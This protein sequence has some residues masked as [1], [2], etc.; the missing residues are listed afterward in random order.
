MKWSEVAERIAD[1]IDDDGYFSAEGREKYRKSKLINKILAEGTSESLRARLTEASKIPVWKGGFDQNAKEIYGLGDRKFGNGYSVKYTKDG[2]EAEYRN[3]ENPSADLTAKCSWYEA[4]NRLLRLIGQGVWTANTT[5]QSSEN[6]LS[7]VKDR[8]QVIDEEEILENTDLTDVLDQSELGGAKTRFKGNVEAI[9]LVNRLYAENRNSTPEEKKIL[10][11][12]VGWGGLSQAFDATN[13]EW[14]KEYEE[15][16]KVLSPE[17]YD[18]A[19]GS[20]LNAHYTS[21]EVIEGIYKALMRFGVRGNNRILEPAMGT[22]NF[23]GYM[24]K[25]LSE[26]ARLY[27]VELDAVTGRIAQKLYPK[28]NI[29]IKGFEDTNYADNSFDIVVGNVPFGGYSVYDTAYNKYNF[30]IHDYFIAKSL[31]KLKPN[32]LMSVITSKGT[33][34]KQNPK[35]RRYYAER[36]ELI[37]AIRLPNNAFK[38]TAGTEVVT[39]ILF[40]RKREERIEATEENTDWLTTGKTEE[41]FEIN[42]YFLRHPERI[43]GRLVK[44]AGLYRCGEL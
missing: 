43:L 14:T 8:G 40:F 19:R 24:P 17:D 11:R 16:K 34:D 30:Y 27:G 12:Y 4:S 20:V 6:P 5:E 7:E 36:A 31:D 22:G 1:L 35:T 32:G 29:Q 25:E 18:R 44:S 15:L 3:P 21:Q 26:S 39:D 33:L 9:K 23:F 38:S 13:E 42:N 2:I 10:A 28:A 41:G 37:G